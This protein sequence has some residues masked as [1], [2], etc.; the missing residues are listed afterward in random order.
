MQ[1][2]ILTAVAVGLAGV[3]SCI[4]PYHPPAISGGVSYLVYDGFIQAGGHDTS[5][6]TL[7]R[8]LQLGD[9]NSP[10]A[11]TGAR[12]WVEDE[13]GNT[14]EFHP[15]QGQ[16]GKYFLPPVR[17]N[18]EPAYRIHIRLASGKSYQ[19]LWEHFRA[20]P[21]IDSISYEH[22]GRKGV[23]IYVNT[24]DPAHQSRFYKWNFTETWEYLT[25]VISKFEIV[26]S[27][28]VPRK[29]EIH[30]CWK[31]ASPT[32]INLFTTA[33][34]SGDVVYSHPVTYVTAESNKLL[35]K[36]NIQVRQQV[37]TREGYEYWSALAKNN[38]T[39]GS[40]F[41]PF[42]SRLTGNIRSM[43]DPEERVF[44]YFAGGITQSIRRFVDVR[45][46]ILDDCDTTEVLQTHQLF[47]TFKYIVNQVPD[48]PDAF[49]VAAPYCVDCR[50]HGGTL[51]K[52]DYWPE[53]WK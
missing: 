25:P 14:F 45:L 4:D 19:S 3:L 21:P 9:A 28:I 34:L 40:V 44:G 23:Q 39:N 37:L 22:N 15:A 50:L 32:H 1:R 51:V 20:S 53:H 48:M 47:D 38:E 18:L 6:V 26:D 2:P 10:I 11:E 46:G 43:D 42:P 8:T 41:D 16:P 7:T 52:P 36:Y 35:I 33:A 29:V 17:L 13:S 5:W 24:H 49:R 30:R 27:M 31:T 12:V